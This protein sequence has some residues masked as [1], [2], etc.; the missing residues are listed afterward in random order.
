MG[1]E[2]DRGSGASIP[3][4]RRNSRLCSMSRR[5]AKWHLIGLV[6]TLLVLPSATHADCR[7][8]S[9]WSMWRLDTS[10]V[11]A[12]Q[13]IHRLESLIA[14]VTTDT[15]AQLPA[16]P[17]RRL[18][19]PSEKP[20]VP[21]MYCGGESLTPPPP[22]PQWERQPACLDGFQSCATFYP[23][24]VPQDSQALHPMFRPDPLDPPPRYVGGD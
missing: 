20:A 12:R 1:L 21:C 13:A 24:L 14:R 2:T 15:R 3:L 5:R 9:D 6:A 22:A 23:T 19:L 8:V 11:S 16:M 17:L 4:L 18:P 7:H 10:A